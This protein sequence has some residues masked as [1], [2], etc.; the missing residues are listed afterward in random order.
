MARTYFTVTFEIRNTTR[1]EEDLFSISF[2]SMP[3]EAGS[4]PP[5]GFFLIYIVSVIFGRFHGKWIFAYSAFCS[6]FKDLPTLGETDLDHPNLS[7]GAKIL[8]N[9]AISKG[10]RNMFL[11]EDPEKY[12]RNA[13]I[14]DIEETE[15]LLNEYK[16]LVIAE[17]KEP[18]GKTKSIRPS[19]I[20]KLEKLADALKFIDGCEQIILQR[21]SGKTYR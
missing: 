20:D 4:I 21:R 10:F 11:W 2:Q 8:S 16:L 18:S 15:R 9:L 14:K 7:A 1:E 19:R 6:T 13:P 5:A 3:L 12:L 17:K